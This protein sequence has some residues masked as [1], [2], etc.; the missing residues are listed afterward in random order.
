[1][2]IEITENAHK[3]LKRLDKQIACKILHYL[4]EIEAL[5][6]PGSKGKALSANFSGL[7]RYRMGDYRI[8]CSIEKDRLLVLLLRIGHRRNI[9]T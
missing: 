1:M 6:D 2:R 4:K 7:W 9:Y 5:E 3:D 8:I